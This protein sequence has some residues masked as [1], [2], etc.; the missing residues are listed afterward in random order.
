MGDVVGEAGDEA[1]GFELVEVRVADAKLALLAAARADID[2]EAERFFELRLG[3]PRV[4]IPARRLRR[5]DVSVGPN[6]D[7]TVATEAVTLIETTV[8]V[9]D[10]HPDPVGHD[11]QA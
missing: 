9:Q 10:L 8:G 6:D 4:G 5:G 11:R 3:R 2:I 1:A 7:P